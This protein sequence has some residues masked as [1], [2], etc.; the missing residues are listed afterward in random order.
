MEKSKK[1]FNRM[2][3]EEKQVYPS[4]KEMTLEEAQRNMATIVA[5]VKNR[6]DNTKKSS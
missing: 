1:D 4:P 5:R 3:E 6:L 2:S